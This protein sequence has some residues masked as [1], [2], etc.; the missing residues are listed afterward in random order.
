MT[1][2]ESNII[3]IVIDTLRDGII[4][5][6]QLKYDNVPFFKDF[7]IYENCIATAPWT[8][9]SHASIFTGKYPS[10]HGIHEDR[11]HKTSSINLN[12]FFPTKL[13]YGTIFQKLKEKGY[14]NYGISRNISIRPGTVF[15][16]GFD[17][18]Q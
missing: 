11:E 14:T 9:P 17:V 2:K 8:I 3:L 5:F 16:R 4:N 15:E 6:Q 7:T 10:E 1:L 13:E 12:D 18:F